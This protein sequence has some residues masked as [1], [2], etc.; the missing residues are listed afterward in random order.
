[1]LVL[2]L[3]FIYSGALEKIK[4]LDDRV[5]SL[6]LSG[7][8]LDRWCVSDEDFR[9]FTGFPS[10]HVF[11]AFWRSVEPFA[12]RIGYW[13]EVSRIGVATVE[14]EVIRPSPRQK[15]QLIDEFYMYC[16]C[17]AAGLKESFGWE[18]WGEH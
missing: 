6:T 10:K 17:V 2:L 11:L 8:L 9:Y 5:S 14:N 7:T 18:V 13:S 3:A 4:E 12:S 15:L 16:L 1:M